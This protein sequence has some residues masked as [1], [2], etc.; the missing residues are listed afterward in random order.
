MRDCRKNTCTLVDIRGG[1][2]HFFLPSVDKKAPADLHSDPLNTSATK[3]HQRV[4]RVDGYVSSVVTE[5]ERV[6]KWALS[7]LCVCF[8][9]FVPSVSSAAFD[10]WIDSG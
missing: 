5:P 2:H 8:F 1:T 10:I 3:G 7:F 9:Y 4:S 6:P